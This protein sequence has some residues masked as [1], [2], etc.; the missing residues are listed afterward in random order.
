VTFSWRRGYAHDLTY[1]GAVA[2]LCEASS[3][4]RLP[5]STLLCKNRAAYAI[6]ASRFHRR[7]PEQLTHDVSA[8]LDLQTPR[9]SAASGELRALTPD[10]AP[11]SCSINPRRLDNGE[12][13]EV[14]SASFG[15]W[16]I[17]SAV[18]QLN[19][20]FCRMTPWLIV[21]IP[22]SSIMSIDS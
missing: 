9:A 21:P 22:P 4:P 19:G 5:G 14:H 1:V 7:L 3:A 17:E 2:R 20:R 11:S 10:C 6:G 18:L 15:Y 12:T 16:G 8:P 13:P